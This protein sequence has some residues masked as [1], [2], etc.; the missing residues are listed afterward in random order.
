MIDWVSIVRHSRRRFSNYVG[1]GRPIRMKK[2]RPLSATPKPPSAHNQYPRQSPNSPVATSSYACCCSSHVSALPIFS[3]NGRDL[4]NG[5]K[6]WGGGPCIL[7]YRL[8]WGTSQ[9]SGCKLV[10]ARSQLLYI[11]LL[12]TGGD[13]RQDKGSVIPQM[14]YI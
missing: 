5:K 6:G 14:M 9:D 10:L 13:R 1:S 4:V 8:K 12:S 2:K 11:I 7:E 3:M